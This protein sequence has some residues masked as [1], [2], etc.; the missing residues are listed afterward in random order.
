M[1][2]GDYKLCERL[3][4]A[5]F[6]EAEQ[7]Q[8]PQL[9]AQA[10]LLLAKQ[11]SNLQAPLKAVDWADTALNRSAGQLPDVEAVAWV[12]RATSCAKQDQPGQAIQAV[13]RALALLQG[14]TPAPLQISVFTGIGLTYSS[15]GMPVQAVEVMQKAAGLAAALDEPARRLRARVNLTY[16]RV[17]AYDLLIHVDADRAHRLMHAALLDEPAMRADSE[18]LATDHS[19]LAYGQSVGAVYSRLGRWQEARV[20]QAKVAAL[21]HEQPDS[22]RCELLADL[23]QTERA[24]GLLA[25]SRAKAQQAQALLHTAAADQ[26]LAESLL[27]ASE[28]A[29]LL[30]DPV[31]ALALFK[32]FHARVVTNE[33]AAFESRVDELTATVAAQSMR[34]EISTL[35]E[36]NAGLAQTFKTLND[37]ALTDALTGVLN[38]RGLEQSFAVLRASGQHLVLV[39][40]DLDHFKAVNDRFSHSMGDAVLRQAAQLMAG[41]LRDRDQLARYGG[42]EF[43]ALLVGTGLPEAAAG[44][45]RLRARIAGFDWAALAPG[46]AVTTSAGLVEVGPLE[47]FEAAVARADALL[48]AAKR[49]GRNRVHVHVQLQQGP[50]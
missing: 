46:L 28:L 14:D 29:E 11:F 48:Y 41:A 39:M 25:E 38:R 21:G 49:A 17:D 42:E 9:A 37:L 19:H 20:L 33:H 45:E 32:R 4:A 47:S 35:Q 13:G 40:L 6:K 10:A 44:A 23:A 36:R 18:L 3:A 27:Q 43:T 8:Q 15:M 22:L 5:I 12:V 7:N 24:L 31:Q 1:A 16:A 26:T 2:A 50:A 30:D 34:L